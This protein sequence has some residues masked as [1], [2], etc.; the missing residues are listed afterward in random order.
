MFDITKISDAELL[1]TAGAVSV[2]F[3]AVA[4][5][6]SVMAGEPCD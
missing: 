5:T 3:S 4:A 1:A 2:D 6:P